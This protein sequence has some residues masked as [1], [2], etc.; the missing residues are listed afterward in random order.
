[1]SKK[2]IYATAKNN[3]EK[4]RNKRKESGMTDSYG[5]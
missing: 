3:G 1:V 2:P 5:V 4:E